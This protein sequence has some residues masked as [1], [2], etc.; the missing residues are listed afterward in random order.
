[1]ALVSH[2][3]FVRE[4]T[5]QHLLYRYHEH[6]KFHEDAGGVAEVSRKALDSERAALLKQA[7]AL[8]AL[9]AKFAQRKDLTSVRRQYRARDAQGLFQKSLMD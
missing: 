4:F 3:G 7:I 2:K 9:Q 8:E 1:M 6:E 5:A